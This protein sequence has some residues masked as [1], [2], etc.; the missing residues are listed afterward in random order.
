MPKVVISMANRRMISKSVINSDAFC[1]MPL[2]A[3]AL[4]MH[5]CVN[6]DDDGFLNNPKRIQRSV[7]ASVDDLKILAGKGFLIGFESGAVVVSHWMEQNSIRKDR[8][9]PTLCVEE[10][11]MLKIDPPG[12]Y[13]LL[14]Q[15][16]EKSL[17]MS[18]VES[19]DGQVATT[20]QPT[21]ATGKDRLSKE[22]SGKD[23]S[24]SIQLG[25]DKGNEVDA[26]PNVDMSIV[27][28]TVD[29][30]NSRCDK[31]FNANSELTKGLISSLLQ[32]GYKPEDFKHVIDVK[33]AEWKGDPKM[34]KYLCPET[35]FGPKFEKYL[36]ERKAVADAYS[37]YD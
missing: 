5:L 6:A 37:E 26:L 15:G 10:L 29:Y 36:N 20:W 2:T 9:T 23:S 34:D 32:A 11:N 27:A 31:H 7:G 25:L 3:Q 13:R 8:Y 18:S 14:G 22:S 33:S 4:Y 12:V 35:L 21:V 19:D 16:E 17:V 30:L 1:D 28:K 24:D